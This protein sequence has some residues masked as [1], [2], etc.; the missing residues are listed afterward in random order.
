MS[1]VP[2]SLLDLGKADLA[3][4]AQVFIVLACRELRHRWDSLPAGIARPNAVSLHI[5]MVA[6]RETR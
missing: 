4:E 2:E 5:P 6:R 1:L 3:G